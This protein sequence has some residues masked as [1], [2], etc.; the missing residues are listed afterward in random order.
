[1]QHLLLKNNLDQSK[2]DALIVFL[3]SLDI[4][5]ELKTN[6]PVVNKKTTFSLSAGIWKDYHIDAK[7]L[8]KEAWNKNS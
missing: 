2:I 1:M 5:A 7:K 3:K 6:A 8:R 4:D